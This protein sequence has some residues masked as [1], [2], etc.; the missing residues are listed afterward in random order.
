MHTVE[1]EIVAMA[2]GTAT[3]GRIA[4]RRLLRAASVS[5]LVV[6]TGGALGAC[7]G[8]PS[9]DEDGYYKFARTRARGEYEYDPQER[10]RLR[11]EYKPS[12]ST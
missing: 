9:R 10:E 8:D 3:P 7:L 4:R 12:G 2:G 6:A 5:T 11:Q 1:K